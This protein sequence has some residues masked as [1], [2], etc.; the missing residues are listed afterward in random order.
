MNPIGINDT[1]I[2]LPA[3]RSLAGHPD[4]YLM[5]NHPKN[6][7][8]GRSYYFIQDGSPEA[9]A[10]AFELETTK[11]KVPGNEATAL[12][13]GYL[14]LHAH[15]M[16]FCRLTTSPASGVKDVP[17]MWVNNGN[18]FSDSL[19]KE[20]IDARDR[21]LGPRNLRS[22][23]E[24]YVDA[25]GIIS[26]GTAFERTSPPPSRVRNG[27]CYS[28][29]LSHEKWTR[30]TAP[31]RDGKLKDNTP[32]SLSMREDLL[33]LSR[34]DPSANLTT[35][36]ELLNLPALGVENNNIFGAA[37]LN[38]APAQLPT[39]STTLAD[40]MGEA[41]EKHI[42]EGDNPAYF[43]HM[44]CLSDLPPSFNP[45]LFCLL[46]A[47][48]FVMAEPFTSVCFQANREHS[49]TPP[50]APADVSDEEMQRAA[51]VTLVAYPP[52]GM[53]TRVHKVPL[54]A[55]GN[56]ES[57]YAPPE[58]IAP[59]LTPRR[60]HAG[61]STITE[62]GP[63]LMPRSA[64]M[65][66]LCRAFLNIAVYVLGQLDPEIEARV[67]SDAFLNSF[68]FVTG[69]GTRRRVGPWVLGP[70]WRSLN[71]QASADL[72]EREKMV[73]QHDMLTERYEAWR[74]YYEHYASHIP[75]AVVKGK[76]DLSKIDNLNYTGY[77]INGRPT[78]PPKPPKKTRKKKSK[79]KNI[80]KSS[81]AGSSKA[82]AASATTSPPD[83]T[84]STAGGPVTRQSAALGRGEAVGINTT[85]QS[86][87]NAT[88]AN[89]TYRV[90]RN[91]PG[92]SSSLSV[93][94]SA[95]ASL[96]IDH[97]SGTVG[98]SVLAPIPAESAV[99]V[100]VS[101]STSGN[102]QS[103]KRPSTALAALPGTKRRKVSLTSA[104]V[105][106]DSESE[107]ED[108]THVQWDGDG[109]LKLVSSFEPRS[110]RPWVI[111]DDVDSD[112]DQGGDVIEG[113]EF[114]AGL[115]ASGY[116][117]EADPYASALNSYYE[118]IV[119]EPLANTSIPIIRSGWLGLGYYQ[120]NER[121]NSL[122]LRQE[123]SCIMFTFY[124]FWTWLNVY[125]PNT[126]RRILGGY[127]GSATWLSSLV[128]SMD[129]GMKARD[130][131]AVF[132]ASAYD[133]D[134]PSEGCV[135]D[136]STAPG[137][138]AEPY[139][140]YLIN[141]IVHVLAAW[142]DY[143]QDDRLLWKAYFIH[144][145]TRDIGHDALMLN[146]T[147]DIYMHVSGSTFRGTGP[148]TFDPCAALPPS[149]HPLFDNRS[150]MRKNMGRIASLVRSFLAG[151]ICSKNVPA[152][153][154]GHGLPIDT[155]PLQ[156]REIYQDHLEL[157]KQFFTDCYKVI[158]MNEKINNV[159][160][161]QKLV[162]DP[163]YYSPFRELSPSRTHLRQ[164]AGPFSRDVV[165]TLE[166]LFSILIFRSITCGTPFSR[167]ERSLF[168]SP[169][170][171]RKARR[172]AADQDYSY[173]CNPGA[174]GRYNCKK[175]NEQKVNELVDKYWEQLL[176]HR[177]PGLDSAD[178]PTFMD[179]FRYFRPVNRPARFP[180]L[181]ALAAY[182]ACAD[183]SYSESILA[184][185]AD[186]MGFLIQHINK[187][188]IDTWECI[189]FVKKRD[190][191]P[192]GKPVKV[193]LAQCVAAFPR[194]HKELSDCLDDEQQAAV[195][196]DYIVT[197]NALCK[198]TRALDERLICL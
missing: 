62:D 78:Q 53:T 55:L 34:W 87:S 25:H 160:L 103:K 148:I 24:P 69:D 120:S 142:I 102:A 77:E 144:L 32:E 146:A 177:W 21:A 140:E 191:T 97:S 40:S 166:G 12:A 43:T 91:A 193:D 163:D 56:R 45:G 65:K 196:M 113:H 158:V 198:F 74:T 181:G 128:H 152:Q 188:P 137:V 161:Y 39:S 63:S 68:S 116:G 114:H 99:P 67:D 106:S 122:L 184:P 98:A 59:D 64:I 180:E 8:D 92:G 123:R 141:S 143:P 195:G 9:M 31:C 129:K 111:D 145:L 14:R 48:V 22:D 3:T 26:G 149:D 112:S 27:R 84:S 28:Y 79:S 5:H 17:V 172:E 38:I 107:G 139:N 131:Q 165:L 154:S 41:G 190:L 150:S 80:A 70:G 197:E 147:W 75:F 133:I 194:T 162:S 96:A 130:P 179:F 6:H 118:A 153:A 76:V 49:G 159:K 66:F 127:D 169:D 46:Y 72:V 35:N 108:M 171:F 18:L 71:A 175:S 168:S 13:N 52:T 20:A 94:S 151:D 16:V 121:A 86:A 155:E 189:G 167:N 186:N 125:V 185:T 57:F 119:S 132:L 101:A 82:A 173:Y 19:K 136:L 182:L 183:L 36:G 61:H 30:I 42:D 1:K 4:L 23:C 170:D 126:V 105:D 58:S 174:Y 135:T 157:F 104:E 29:G 73:S 47:G 156:V 89:N 134:L 37:Q 81:S 85:E 110:D 115:A 109:Y 2:E 60:W 95:S 124:T 90:L 15:D 117:T 164:A 138:D 187:A 192:K 10:L 7:G 178:P 44:V 88:S 51:R 11:L 100:P 83:D 50:I 54:C 93:T 176:L 33:R